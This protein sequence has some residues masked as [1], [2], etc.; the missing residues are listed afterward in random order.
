MP[1]LVGI[2]LSLRPFRSYHS[3]FVR[4]VIFVFEIPVVSPNTSVIAR[5]PAI[6]PLGMLSHA[7]LGPTARSFCT[8]TKALPLKA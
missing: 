3:P 2:P 7:L 6:M 5:A 4:F 8:K 1:F